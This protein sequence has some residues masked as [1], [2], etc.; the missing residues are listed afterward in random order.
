VAKAA[1]PPDSPVRLLEQQRR[2]TPFDWMSEASRSNQAPA[3][4][5]FP[6]RKAGGIHERQ[7]LRN[8]NVSGCSSI[9]VEQPWQKAKA[10]TG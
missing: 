5:S 2:I 1:Q 10:D 8:M 7:N 9:V 6:S 3:I 4:V